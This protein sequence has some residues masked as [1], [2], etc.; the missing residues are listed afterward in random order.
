MTDL[1]MTEISFGRESLATAFVQAL[2]RL[3]FLDDVVCYVSRTSAL[4]LELS[5]A[6][7]TMNCNETQPSDNI[8]TLSNANSHGRSST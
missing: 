6:Q 8:K 2:I 5:L 4:R 3:V 1:V 7:M